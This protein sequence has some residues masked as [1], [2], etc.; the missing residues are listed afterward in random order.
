MKKV[1]ILDLVKRRSACRSKFSKLQLP[2]TPL[3]YAP[4]LLKHKEANHKT[5]AYRVSSLIFTLMNQSIRRKPTIYKLIPS[6][7]TYKSMCDLY[8]PSIP[9]LS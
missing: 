8:I 2:Q 9:F 4:N 7:I 6:P 3:H 1:S 5:T